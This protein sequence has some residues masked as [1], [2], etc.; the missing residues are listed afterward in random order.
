VTSTGRTE[1]ENGPEQDLTVP[2]QLA[3]SSPAAV[4]GL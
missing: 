1:Q 3:G 2:L 4:A